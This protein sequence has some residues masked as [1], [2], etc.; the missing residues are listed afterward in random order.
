MKLSELIENDKYMCFNRP[1][2][3]TTIG[4]THIDIN[5]WEDDIV[6]LDQEVA[7]DL[8]IEGDLK[9][10]VQDINLGTH[11]LESEWLSK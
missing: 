7:V 1:M 10:Y 11:E 6:A 2:Y 4:K 3:V 5:L 8:L 9:I